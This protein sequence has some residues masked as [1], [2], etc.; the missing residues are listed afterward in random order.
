M[1]ILATACSWHWAAHLTSRIGYRPGDLILAGEWSAC[2]IVC[3]TLATSATLDMDEPQLLPTEV[4]SWKNFDDIALHEAF[5]S[6]QAH[7]DIHARF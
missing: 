7:Q 6:S 4:R 1:L 5:R 2:R 3:P